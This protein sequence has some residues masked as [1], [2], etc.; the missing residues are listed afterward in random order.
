MILN[1]EHNIGLKSEWCIPM[2]SKFFIY[3]PK[4]STAPHK[5]KQL[6][7]VSTS[8]HIDQIYFLFVLHWWRLFLLHFGTLGPNNGVIMPKSFL[9]KLLE[10]KWLLIKKFNEFWHWESNLV[11]FDIGSRS[12]VLPIGD[13]FLTAKPSQVLLNG[14]RRRGLKIGQVPVNIGK[15]V[16]RYKQSFCPTL[17]F[18]SAVGSHKWRITANLYSCQ[19]Y[20]SWALGRIQ[21]SDVLLF[22]YIFRRFSHQIRWSFHLVQYNL[23]FYMQM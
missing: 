7:N 18:L 2:L 8:L 10:K 14:M 17:L 15:F 4:W 11:Q 6:S 20:Q 19:I 22:H 1:N 23:S 16:Y 5:K 3:S 9:N 12:D 21:W 13:K